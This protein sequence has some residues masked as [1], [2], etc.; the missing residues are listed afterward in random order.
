MRS[1]KNNPGNNDTNGLNDIDITTANPQKNI[2][3]RD[4]S[5]NQDMKECP[6]IL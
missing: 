1:H 3:V 5:Q 4:P 6:N 2:M